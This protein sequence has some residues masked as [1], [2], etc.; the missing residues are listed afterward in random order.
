MWS[1]NKAMKH[2]SERHEWQSCVGRCFQWHDAKD[3]LPCFLSCSWFRFDYS[4]CVIAL[5]M[6][7]SVLHFTATTAALNA[8]VSDN[9]AQTLVH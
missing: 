5:Q 7:I 3:L 9:S 6:N 4:M 8:I 2:E 1:A